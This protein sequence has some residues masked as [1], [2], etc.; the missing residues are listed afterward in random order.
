[1]LYK[2][3]SFY[4]PPESTSYETHQTKETLW[5][6]M[7]TDQLTDNFMSVLCLE[8]VWS[9]LHCVIQRL[10]LSGFFF[11]KKNRIFYRSIF[12]SP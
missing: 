1:M 11:F 2:N 5:H 8:P 4:A 3:L 6:D 10:K 9:T 12:Q 7:Q